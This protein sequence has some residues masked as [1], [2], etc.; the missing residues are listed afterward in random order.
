MTMAKAAAREICL[1]RIGSGSPQTGRFTAAALQH[2]LDTAR[3]CHPVLPCGG[4]TRDQIDAV[5]FD[6]LTRLFAGLARWLGR[7]H[8]TGRPTTP[9]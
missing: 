9:R 5:N 1:S 4:L 6:R 7:R 8:T 3:T 2:G